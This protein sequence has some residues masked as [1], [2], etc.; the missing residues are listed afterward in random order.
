VLRVNI[1][2]HVFYIPLP[3]TAT[4]DC[5]IFNFADA[6]ATAHRFLQ[7]IST[8]FPDLDAFELNQSNVA[9]SCLLRDL[10][11]NYSPFTVDLNCNLCL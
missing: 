6:F 2:F 1:R 10:E 4:W 5:V 8:V 7:A 3:L 9:S 11:Y